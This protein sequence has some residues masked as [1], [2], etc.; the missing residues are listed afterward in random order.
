MTDGIKAHQLF[1]S[2]NSTIQIPLK[3]PNMLSGY[4]VHAE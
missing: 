1:T 3:F 2:Y 4:E